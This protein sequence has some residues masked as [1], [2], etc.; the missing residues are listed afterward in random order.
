[1][2]SA[3]V[4]AC[5]GNPAFAVESDVGV[6]F[7]W[8]NFDQGK[9]ADLE[10]HWLIRLDGRRSWFMFFGWFGFVAGHAAPYEPLAYSP[11]SR[12][13]S[14]AFLISSRILLMSARSPGVLRLPWASPSFASISKRSEQASLRRHSASFWIFVA[15]GLTGLLMIEGLLWWASEVKFLP[16]EKAELCLLIGAVTPRN[17]SASLPASRQEYTVTL[18][19]VRD[20]F[21]SRHPLQ[22][23][24]LPDSC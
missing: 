14:A 20:G 3:Q 19:K 15:A 9:G 21:E 5:P 2:E 10:G 4:L 24:N 12:T 8:L 1:M 6:G 13:M 23:L 18:R 7:T 17:Q 22:D 11:L 16:K